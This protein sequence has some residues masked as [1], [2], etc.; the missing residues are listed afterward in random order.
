MSLSPVYDMLSTTL[1]MGGAQE[2]LALPLNGKKSKIE[3]EDLFDYFACSRLGL[4]DKVIDVVV[5]RF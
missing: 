3:R 5:E 4:T 1:A 2:E